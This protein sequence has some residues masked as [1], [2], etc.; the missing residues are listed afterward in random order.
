MI[1][2]ASGPGTE[3]ILAE[4]LG[5][6]SPSPGIPGE[7]WGGGKSADR[8][9]PHPSPPPEYQGR[10]KTRAA[11]VRILIDGMK[12]PVWLSRFF[13]PHSYTGN[14]LFELHLPGNPLLAGMVLNRIVELRARHAEPGEFTARA[15][16][17][18]R[19]D[20]SQAE[21]VAAVVAAG[22]EAELDAGRRLMAGELTKRLRPCIDQLADAL[23]LVEAEIDF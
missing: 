11:R 4:L 2:R 3:E 16:F 22:N 13:A 8:N 5:D 17:N 21:G 18:G 9:N 1:V 23:A 19:I 20:L 15:Y 6:S 10:G 14:D 7:G 12:V